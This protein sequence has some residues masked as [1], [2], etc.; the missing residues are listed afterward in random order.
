VARKTSISPA[1]LDRL[2][3]LYNEQR[4]ALVSYAAAED[5]TD[6]AERGVA[7]A[8]Q[9]LKD[10]QAQVETAYEILVGL[11]G[12]SAAAE[13]TG[14]RASRTRTTATRGNQDGHGDGATLGNEDTNGDVARAVA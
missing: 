12:A 7:A 13:L 14:R 1:R 11:M 5:A 6:A 2:K 10:A 9:R 3:E 4:R 8:K